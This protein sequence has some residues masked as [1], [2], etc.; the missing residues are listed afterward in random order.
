MSKHYEL[1]LTELFKRNISPIAS[2]FLL[3]AVIIV[4]NIEKY[5]I[6]SEIGIISE[7]NAK[8]L[9]LTRNVCT[10]QGWS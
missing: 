2:T 5:W 9:L 7:Q 6:Y 4:D 1:H 8:T 10:I 3:I